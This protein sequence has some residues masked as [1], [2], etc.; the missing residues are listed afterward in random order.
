MCPGFSGA[1]FHMDNLSGLIGIILSEPPHKKIYILLYITLSLKI[2]EISEE[3]DSR[4]KEFVQD[5]SHWQAGVD[6]SL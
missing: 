1:H 3:H 4:D 5:D 6:A 2:D